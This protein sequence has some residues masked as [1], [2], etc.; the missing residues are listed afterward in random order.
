MVSLRPLF[1]SVF[2]K[3]ISL[4]VF[5]GE[6][7]F[8][9]QTF[10]LALIGFVLFYSNV[11]SGYVDVFTFDSWQFFLLVSVAAYVLC[12]FILYYICHKAR[13]ILEQ[14]VM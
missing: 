8:F 2:R 5:V 12:S 4:V 7:F 3:V 6:W 13:L 14:E 1:L 9:L 11:S 10:L